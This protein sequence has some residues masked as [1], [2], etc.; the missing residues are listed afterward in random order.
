MT[1]IHQQPSSCTPTITMFAPPDELN[2]H[3]TTPDQT[4]AEASHTPIT[5][6]KQGI[7]TKRHHYH[8]AVHPKPTSAQQM[9]D[10]QLTAGH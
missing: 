1:S 4:A 6:Q 7:H 5:I 8:T 2:T 3:R 10:E 9:F